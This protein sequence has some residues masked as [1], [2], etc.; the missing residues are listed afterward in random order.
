MTTRITTPFT[1]AAAEVVAGMHLS[2]RRAIVT[3]DAVMPGVVH[4]NLMRH[5]DPEA[6]ACQTVGRARPVSL[7]VRS[8]TPIPAI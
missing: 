4:T 1:A 5:V 8:H 3:V 6:P 7:Q 2:G